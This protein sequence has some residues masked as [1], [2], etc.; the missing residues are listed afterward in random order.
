MSSIL[1]RIHLSPR[2]SRFTSSYA[3]SCKIAHPE[4]AFVIFKSVKSL[5]ILFTIILKNLIPNKFGRLGI[6]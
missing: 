6:K 3:R 1:S 4:P 2:L 5:D